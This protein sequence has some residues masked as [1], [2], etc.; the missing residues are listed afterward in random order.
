MRILQI[1]TELDGGGVDRLLYDYSCR[2]PNYIHCDFAIC[3]K[4]DGILEQPLI[5]NGSKIFRYERLRSGF[6]KSV[7]SLKKIISQ[8]NYDIVHV[9]S[10][11]LSFPALYAAWKCGVKVRI[12]HSH[13]AYES[14]S[15][16][17]KFCRKI[18]TKLTK[19]FAT[20][21]F[22]CGREAGTWEWGKNADFFAMRNA[23]DI[24]KFYFSEDKRKE[25]REKYNIENNFVVGNVA[26]FSY[27]KNHEYLIDVFAELTKK[28]DNALL[29]LV[30]RGEDEDKIRTK[31]NN[32]GL[33]ERVMFMG[34]RN[35]V[36]DLLNA[37][38][39][40]VLPSRYE[41]LPVVMVEVQANGLPLIAADTITDEVKILDNVKYLPLEIEKQQWVDEILRASRMD[42]A[43]SILKI[44]NSGYDINTE[45]INLVNKYCS[46]GDKNA[47]RK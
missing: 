18:F 35:D 6:F 21:L 24:K 13:I 37:M 22:A 15:I 1:S 14:E 31:V 7:K 23:I 26:R 47:M 34:I 2:F 28:Q 10:G 46:L 3:G 11:Y 44:K 25:L 36:H 12:A 32:L 43:D 41:G 19:I 20:S 8:G 33:S 29:M 17:K 38:D 45:A 16:A 9:H 27:Q 5:N 4:K 42:K 30:G 39:V 40:F